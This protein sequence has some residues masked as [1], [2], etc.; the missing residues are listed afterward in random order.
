MMRLTGRLSLAMTLEELGVARHE[1]EAI[2][3]KFSRVRG[4]PP[5]CMA[6]WL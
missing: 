6:W 4:G 3:G 2:C 5:R 1:W